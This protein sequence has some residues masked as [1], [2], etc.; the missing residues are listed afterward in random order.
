[1]SHQATAWAF[2]MRHLKPATKIVLLTLADCHNPEHGC[3]PS[4]AFLA[5]ACEMSERSIRD[6]LTKLEEL[7]LITRHRRDKVATRFKSDAYQL[8]FD[9]VLTEAEKPAANSAGGQ[10]KPAAN[11]DKSQRQNL[12]PNLVKEIGKYARE[13]R[14]PTREAEPRPLPHCRT[15]IPHGSTSEDAWDRWLQARGYPRLSDLSA[16]VGDGWDAPWPRPPS[17]DEDD[18]KVKATEKWAAW[19]MSRSPVRAVS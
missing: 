8:H 9:R 18:W 2:A 7:G 11:Y 14:A 10:E 5:E 16:P 13:A 17:D 3:F 15:C 1:M 12:P 4:Q 19:H 6:H